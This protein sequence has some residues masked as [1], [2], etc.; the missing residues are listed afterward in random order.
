MVVLTP[1]AKKLK[2]RFME[3]GREE[4]RQE[5]IN[6]KKSILSNILS[7]NYSLDETSKLTGLSVEEIT[8]ILN[9]H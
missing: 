9:H 1:S 2:E 6:L 4:L 7:N 8:E 3:E 5:N